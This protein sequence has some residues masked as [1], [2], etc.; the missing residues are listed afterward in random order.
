[1]RAAHEAQFDRGLQGGPHARFT[2]SRQHRGAVVYGA[3]VRRANGRGLQHVD[4][5]FQLNN[6]RVVYTMWA[7][8]RKS[9]DMNTGQVG[10]HD[11]HQVRSVVIEKRINEI[12]NRL[13]KSKEE[14]HN[15]PAELAE[16]RQACNS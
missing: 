8:L 12:V 14:K 10:F 6:V 5:R 4:P 1:M 16:L 3:R 9:G 13:N 15:H 2:R 7:N 11:K